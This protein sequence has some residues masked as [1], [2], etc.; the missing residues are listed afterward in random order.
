MLAA[1]CVMPGLVPLAPDSDLV[2]TCGREVNVPPLFTVGM[3]PSTPAAQDRPEHER[4]K[5]ERQE[6]RSR[7]EPW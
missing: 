3:Q 5:E 1:L 2:R 4:R 6:Q 7:P